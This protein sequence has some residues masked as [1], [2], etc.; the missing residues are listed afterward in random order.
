MS[1]MGGYDEEQR[2]RAERYKEVPL[3]IAP[4]QE[5][6]Y[7]RNLTGKDETETVVPEQAQPE[8]EQRERVEKEV[9]EPG[10]FCRRGNTP[11]TDRTGQCERLGRI[12]RFVRTGG[13]G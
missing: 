2:K 12:A 6:A 4:G 10:G 13:H 3:V 7:L 8:T 1:W 9:Q 5:E 11:G